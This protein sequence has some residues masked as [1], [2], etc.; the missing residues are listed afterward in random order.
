MR[1]LENNFAVSLVPVGGLLV[2]VAP[3]VHPPCSG[4]QPLELMMSAYSLGMR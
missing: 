3:R 1:R 2:T 4:D